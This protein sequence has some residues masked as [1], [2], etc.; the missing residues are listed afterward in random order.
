M[1]QSDGLRSGR[2]ITRA[3]VDP[4]FGGSAL[5]AN[6][7]LPFHDGEL[8]VFVHELQSVPQ[9]FDHD[10]AGRVVRALDALDFREGSAHRRP[11]S[12]TAKK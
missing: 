9:R 6:V 8:A 7:S 3:K 1:S 10:H 4:L 2:G 5:T 11:K 12:I